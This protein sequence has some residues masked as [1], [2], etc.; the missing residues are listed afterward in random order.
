MA[1][2]S[3]EL[4]TH[5]TDLDLTLKSYQ[6]R[7]PIVISGPSGVG[8]GT[9]I[10]RLLERYADTLATTVSHTTRQPRPGE[11]NHED[12]H[13]VS[14]REFESL[15]KSNAFVE[16]T[17]FSG[18]Y[19]GT[20]RQTIK[21]QQAKGKIPVLEIEMSGITQIKMNKALDMRFAFI[22][23]PS[24]QVLEER[25]HRR[26]TESA[27]SI[28]RRLELAKVEME[29]AKVPGFHDIIIVNTNLDEAYKELEEWVSGG[30][31]SALAT[32]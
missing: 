25:L 9:L 15:I 12:Y 13:F 17:F 30:A 27:K 8:K 10:G 22:S 14:I 26:G 18:N 21:D 24:L 31:G 2:G 16:Y 6:D 11:V 19:Y 7:R 23:P 28:E 5:P 20:S 3:S 1:L 32:C 4:D 29:R